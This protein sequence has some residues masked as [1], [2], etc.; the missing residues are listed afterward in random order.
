MQSLDLGVPQTE[1]LLSPCESTSLRVLVLDHVDRCFRAVVKTRS[2]STWCRAAP[3]TRAGLKDRGPKAIFGQSND[4]R[5]VFS[6]RVRSNLAERG[7]VVLLLGRPEAQRSRQQ[8]E[9]GGGSR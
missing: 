5:S 4:A 7:Q 1:L 9:S 8:S 2:S 6:D 3:P